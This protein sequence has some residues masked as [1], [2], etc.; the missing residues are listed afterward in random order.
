M[1]VHG[2]N[3]D[4][5]PYIG[6]IEYQDALEQAVCFQKVVDCEAPIQPSQALKGEVQRVGVR[7]LFRTPSL[8]DH[9]LRGERVRNACNNFVLHVDEVGPRVI[10]TLRP[11]M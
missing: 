3:A 1:Y 6:G 8:S 2:A 4:L 9:E 7:S 11:N 5:S 10:G